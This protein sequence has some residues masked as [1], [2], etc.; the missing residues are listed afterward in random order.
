MKK[1]FSVLVL[2]LCFVLVGCNE[3]S[4]DLVTETKLVEKTAE[5]AVTKQEI[6]MGVAAEALMEEAAQIDAQ[7][8]ELEFTEL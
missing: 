8:D 5:T 4:E 6:D 7:I 2:S 1:L 3:S